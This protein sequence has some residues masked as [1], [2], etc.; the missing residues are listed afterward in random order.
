VTTDSGATVLWVTLA[1][2][3]VVL[4]YVLV[5]IPYYAIFTKAGQPGWAGFVPV[6]NW[7]VLFRVI[8]RPG[9]WVLLF[10]IPI[11]NV[12]V[13]IIAMLEL[14]Q[15]F[16]KGGWFTVGLILLNWVFLLI[17]GFGD[18]VYQGPVA[19]ATARAPRPDG[20]VPPPPR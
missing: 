7:V 17:L 16:G 12:V 9:W 2:A 4:T 8:G 6:Y 18:A 10:L 13:W 20:L 3:F 19:V 15:S 14:A 1:V 5:A 11:V